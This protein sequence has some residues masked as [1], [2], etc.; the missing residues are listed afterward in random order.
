MFNVMEC[1][2]Q[3]GDGLISLH[4]NLELIILCQG[5]SFH[6]STLIFLLFVPFERLAKLT[7][8]IRNSVP[9]QIDVDIYILFLMRKWDTGTSIE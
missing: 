6:L 8:E 3:L 7:L 2:G 5:L 4:M 9:E 1:L